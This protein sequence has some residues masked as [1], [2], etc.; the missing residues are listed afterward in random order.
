MTRKLIERVLLRRRTRDESGAV[1]IMT[2]ILVVVL[3]SVAALGVDLGNAMNRKQVTQNSSDFAALAGANGLP[4]TSALTVQLV[5]DYLNTNAAS[6]DGGTE[7]NPQAGSTITAAM[8]TDGD[9]V[10]GEVTFPDG[11]TRIQV[12]SPAARVQFGM[13][14]VMG[15]NDTC[16][17]SVSTARISSPAIGMSP[18]YSTDACDQGP[19]VL[20]SDAGGPSIPFDVPT[21][22]FDA[23][24][25]G[26]VLSNVDPNPNPSQIPVQ[27]VGPT[28]GPQIILTGTSMGTGPAGV[29]RVGFFSSDQSPPILATPKA[30]PAQTATQIAV[31]VPNAVASYQDVWWIRVRNTTTGDW[32]ARAQARPLLVGEV[33]LSCDPNSASGNFGSIDIPRGGN[34]LQDLE[35][36]I[37]D[38]LREGTTLR[39]WLSTPIPAANVCQTLPSPPS[40]ISTDTLGRE[41]TNCLQ[42]VTGLKANPAFDGY[43]KNPGGKLLTDT[44]DTCQALGRPARGPHN[45]NS[46]VLSCF[47]EDR[48]VPLKLSDAVGYTGIDPLFTQEI[49]ESPRFMIVP[50]IQVDPSGTKW[51]PI[52][53]FTPAFITD[54]PTGASKQYP[55]VTGATDNGLVV[56]HPN[57]LRAIRV[58]FFSMNALPAPADGGELQDYFGAGPKIITMVN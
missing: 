19:Q 16:V 23:Q 41:N 53:D 13:A 45:E 44:S 12:T 39:K 36:N 7:C 21:L 43:L 51:M 5:A 24:T 6:N 20:K 10:N 2:G 11:T 14:A 30:T 56:E 49:W 34:D 1:A 32:S 31:D 22:H 4:D 37:R 52:I 38:G 9:D 18:Y 57:K 15:F 17:S 33:T 25:N 28:D 35:G 27:P 54:Q 3:V 47:L 58:F 42:S 50:K 55:L 29:D 26:S 40:V 46:D 48:P 8:L